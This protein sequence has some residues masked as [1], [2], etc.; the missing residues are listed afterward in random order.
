MLCSDLLEPST[1][2]GLRRSTRWALRVISYN[3]CRWRWQSAGPA[4]IKAMSGR[5]FEATRFRFTISD[6]SDK[7]GCRAV[8]STQDALQGVDVWPV[9]RRRTNDDRK[10]AILD[11]AANLFAGKG[12]PRPAASSRCAIP[13]AIA[14]LACSLGRIARGIGI[15]IAKGIGDFGQRRAYMPGMSLDFQIV[16]VER[17]TPPPANHPAF[18]ILGLRGR[19]LPKQGAERG[20]LAIAPGPF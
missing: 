13:A 18:V 5:Q 4:Q 15:D 16:F 12:F 19:R 1:P 8:R 17:P 20:Q 3:L 10:E 6:E 7:E 2:N 14:G 9:S 11:E